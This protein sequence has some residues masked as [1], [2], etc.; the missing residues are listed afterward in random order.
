MERAA[1]LCR[2]AA[3]LREYMGWPLPP[4]KRAEHERIVA[5]TREALGEVAF[6]AAWIRGHSLPLKE[7]I[8]DT[9]SDG[10]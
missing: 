9:L 6:D 8:A 3:A 4:A 10:E 5:A 7:V 1:W 2:T